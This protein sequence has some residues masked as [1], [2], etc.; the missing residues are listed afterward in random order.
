[1]QL[2]LR[3][4]HLGLGHFSEIPE[5]CLFSQVADTIIF[6]VLYSFHSEILLKGK[7]WPDKIKEREVLGYSNLNYLLY[8]FYISLIILKNM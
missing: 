8:H 2:G 4:R 7:I 6:T 1:M 5:M 3:L